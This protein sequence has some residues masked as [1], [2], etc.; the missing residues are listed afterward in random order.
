M[1]RSR[2]CKDNKQNFMQA[3]IKNKK[4]V[5]APN[6][7][8]IHVEPL[9]NKKLYANDRVTYFGEFQK[10]AKH[11]GIIA[12]PS[13]YNPNP[14]LHKAGSAKIKCH[15]NQKDERVTGRIEA[16]YMAK[17]VPGHKY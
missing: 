9:K 14:L 13:S 7:Y 17:F 2:S 6:Q 5:P 12:G 8:N 1:M 15:L 16:E 10:K 4:Q 3:L 11:E